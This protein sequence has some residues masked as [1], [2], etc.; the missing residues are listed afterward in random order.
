LKK[1]EDNG[2][3]LR[4]VQS[5]NINNAEKLI[6]KEAEVSASALLLTAKH[7]YCEIVKSLL[8]SFKVNLELEYI[9]KFID[10]DGNSGL[11]LALAHG[12]YEVANIL[13]TYDKK[14]K[15]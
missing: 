6:A 12:H 9:L 3:L 14:H 5:N 1:F 7:G 2:D 11:H 4:E 15:R 10:G 8:K 13:L